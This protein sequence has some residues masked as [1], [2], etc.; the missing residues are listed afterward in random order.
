MQPLSRKEGINILRKSE[1]KKQV[2]HGNKIMKK[3]WLFSIK[4]FGMTGRNNLMQTFDMSKR[5][6]YEHLTANKNN[7]KEERTGFTEEKTVNKS[8]R[9]RKQNSILT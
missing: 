8:I 5:Y 2:H 4:P 1:K 6:F 7:S 9:L 3:K